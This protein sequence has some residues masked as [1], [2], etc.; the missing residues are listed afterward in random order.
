[1]GRH[2]LVGAGVA[3]WFDTLQ[4]DDTAFTLGYRANMNEPVRRPTWADVARLYRL[5][6]RGLVE[7]LTSPDS[8]PYVRTRAERWG[9]KVCTALGAGLVLV[10]LIALAHDH[11]PQAAIYSGVWRPKALEISAT[12]SLLFLAV[13]YPLVSWRVGYLMVLLVPGIS[14]EPRLSL[15]VALAVVAVFVAAGLRHTR[16]V[17]WS[18]WTL[19]LLPIWV[20]LGSHP[21]DALL[22]TTVVTV[23]TGAVDARAATTQAGRAL[24]H[25]VAQT[26]DE[27]ARRAVLEERARIAR[28]MHDVV[29]HHMSMIAVQAETAPYRLGELA[30]GVSSELSERTVA[31]FASLSGAARAALTDLRT[32]LGVLRSD[33]TPERTP[34]PQLKDVPK[35]VET[36]RRAGVPVDLS[37]PPGDDG[38]P[39][40]VGLCAYRIVQE[41]LSNAGRHSP[42]SSVII[43]IG[44]DQQRIR[45]DVINGPPASSDATVV[46]DASKRRKGHGIAGMRERVALLGGSL[47]AVPTQEG[48]YA[49][50]ATIPLARP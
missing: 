35:L 6:M 33:E 48:G 2:T 45:L 39:A 4:A 23:V 8:A 44:R 24:A 18:M 7:V 28:E 26:E 37:M 27:E 5:A 10:A 30:D 16:L 42:G 17:L 41:A 19:M 43:N 36:I 40:A 34:Q 9:V 12:L 11:P 13:R 29:A 21:L 32:V 3:L 47:W 20:W 31:E 14:D 50:V 1:M 15:L 22:A 38:V 49:V 46:G 25:Q